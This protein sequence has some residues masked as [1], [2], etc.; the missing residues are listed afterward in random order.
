[1]LIFGSKIPSKVVEN[2]TQKQHGFWGGFFMPF[3]SILS[4]FG[5]L[6]V[7]G[8]RSNFHPKLALGGSGVPVWVVWV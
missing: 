5:E 1:M 2:V 4:P 3:G 7:A 8:G 6:K